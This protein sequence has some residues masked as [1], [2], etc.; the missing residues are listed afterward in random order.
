LRLA[1]SPVGQADAG[2]AVLNGRLYVIGGY[3][4]GPDDSLS[5][6]F[7]YDGSW[8][9]EKDYPLK[10]WGL[11]S[12]EHRGQIYCFAGRGGGKLAF[13]FDGDSWFR[14]RN[15]PD[16]LN[17]AQGLMAVDEGRFIML[18][19]PKRQVYVYYPTSDL[20]GP[21]PKMPAPL[22]WAS[23]AFIGE[24]LYV[25][26][27][28][29]KWGA[30]R[31]VWAFDAESLKWREA[32]E[33]PEARYGMIRNPPVVEGKMPIVGGYDSKRFFSDSLLFDGERFEEGPKVIARDGVSGGM[34]GDSLVIAGG[35]DNRAPRG[36]RYVEAFRL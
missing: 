26:G 14:I 36:L 12:V 32:C 19:G 30:K 9:R 6:V 18:L 22:R 15:V 13:R 34:V 8:M 33:L 21:L 29:G 25:V 20:Y 5:C 17:D 16:D 24:Y 3:G 11:A 28:F 10:A 23:A 31:T 35:R 7:S 27:G 1:D 2:S 4:D